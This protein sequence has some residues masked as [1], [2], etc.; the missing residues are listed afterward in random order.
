[1]VLAVG[2]YFPD[3][4]PATAPGVGTQRRFTSVGLRVFYRPPS[5][6]DFLRP[7]ISRAD[8]T[9]AGGTATFTVTARDERPAGDPRPPQVRQVQVLAR[10]GSGAWRATT[11]APAGGDTFTG[12]LPGVSG[13][14]VDYF[15][16]VVDDAGNV[17]VSSNKGA[18]F[19]ETATPVIPSVR[20]PATATATTGTPFA[21]SG[22]IVDADSTS[23]TASVDH[24]D[25]TPT[26]QLPLSLNGFSLA[27]TYADAGIYSVDVTV[28]DGEGNCATA[29]T[30]VTVTPP[31]QPTLKK[32]VPLLDSAC[33]TPR[34][35]IVSRWGYVN[36]NTFPVIVT[37]GPRNRFSPGRVWRG[38]PL[39]FRMGENHRVFLTVH[40]GFALTWTVTGNAATSTPSSS[41]PAC[42]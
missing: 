34:G 17:A 19:R 18:L 5:E 7:L 32:P 38:Q 27:H 41:L 11:L 42:S 40:R 28:C 29:T 35:W 36:P 3:L 26:E 10:D 15:V 30:Q 33:R 23:W 31:G 16:Q 6:T 4:D 24:G 12:T 39:L 9:L 22:S 21:A 14:R 1:V 8:A 25:G 37:F 13:T 20:V 2:Q